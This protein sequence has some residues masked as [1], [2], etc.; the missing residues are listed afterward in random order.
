MKRRL[1]AEALNKRDA[2]H[3][4]ERSLRA[5]RIMN[6]IFEL[7]VFKRAKIILF[8]TSIR[9]EV[10]TLPFIEKAIEMG[11]K[12]VVPVVKKEKKELSLY[13]IES[14]DELKPG[15]MGIPEPIEDENRR[16]DI[17]SVDLV[18]IPGVAYDLE[19]N[20]IGYGSG[21]YDRILSKRKKHIP[22]VAPAFRE[23]LVE[24]IPT[25]EHDIKVDFIVTEEGVVCCDG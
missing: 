16:V 14:L 24:L 1:R 7:D 18:I 21:Y 9:S 4:S 13:E 23:Q 6:H 20:R 5:E 11:K 2:I 19:G 15:Y 12:V 3:E 22:V 25:E 10:N 8:Y 17:N